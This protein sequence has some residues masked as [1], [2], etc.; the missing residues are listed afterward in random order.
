MG[1]DDSPYRRAR[2]AAGLALVGLVV[3]L[4]VIDALSP[5]F[6][7]DTVQLVL[8]TGTAMALLGVEAWRSLLK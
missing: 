6:N 2:I 7:A 3:V 4:A 8:F 1:P 5:A